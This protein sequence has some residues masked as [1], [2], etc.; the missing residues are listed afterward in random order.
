MSNGQ[1][2]TEANG[3]ERDSNDVIGIDSPSRL[4]IFQLF[5][6]KVK[7]HFLRS[8]TLCPGVLSTCDLF[9]EIYLD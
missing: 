1:N 9:S 3:A 8:V 7:S 4:C 6:L 5:E 2:G